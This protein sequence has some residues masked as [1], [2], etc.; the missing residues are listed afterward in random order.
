MAAA[1]PFQLWEDSQATLLPDPEINNKAAEDEVA[2]RACSRLEA[3]YF[4]H[5]VSQLR[6]PRR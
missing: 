3:H 2:N 6:S 1:L 5:L 4:Y